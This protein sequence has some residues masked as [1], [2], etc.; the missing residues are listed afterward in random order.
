MGG[1]GPAE[2]DL[3]SL[4]GDLLMIHN[5]VPRLALVFAV[6]ACVGAN[7]YAAAPAAPP[8]VASSA[9]LDLKDPK[10]RMS[11]AIGTGIGNNFKTQGVAVDENALAAGIAD[12]IAGKVA[13]SE[14]DIRTTMD[15]VRSDLLAK[16]Q[17]KLKADGA[18]NAKAGADYLAANAK[19]PGV[20]TTAVQSRQI[21]DWQDAGTQGH[22]QGSLSRHLHRRHRI[23]QLRR[24]WRAGD[25]PGKRRDRR[26]D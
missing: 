26:L 3:H 14:A 15:Q 4:T 17:A 6:A 8:A 11:Y 10:Q 12:A 22:R 16:Q 25:V 5:R 2:S 21:G 18:T 7:S 1:C 13:M 24:P 23:R 19:K 20:K 9:Q